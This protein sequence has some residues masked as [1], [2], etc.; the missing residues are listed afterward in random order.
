MRESHPIA[1]GKPRLLQTYFE[2][3]EIGFEFENNPPHLISIKRL[4]VS[5]SKNLTLKFQ[6]SYDLL[7]VG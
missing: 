1:I 5:T 6:S 4:K 7:C 2:T 3:H